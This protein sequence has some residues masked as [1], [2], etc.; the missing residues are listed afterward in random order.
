MIKTKKIFF[1][2]VILIGVVMVGI[3]AF[4]P[5]TKSSTLQDN[6]MTMAEFNKRISSKETPVLVYFHASWCAV[7]AKLNPVINEFELENKDKLE[8]LRIETT[9]DKEIAEEMEI[10]GL[11]VLMFYK[12]GN[13]QWIHVGAIQ[14]DNLK[15]KIGL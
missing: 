5:E 1:S 3:F 11:P 13:R 7:C 6:G 2:I 8:V 9:K 12:N 10:D 15:E 4:S 14:K